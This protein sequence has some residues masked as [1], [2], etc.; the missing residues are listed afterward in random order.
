VLFNEQIAS[1]YTTE[2]PV[3]AAAASLLLLAALFQ[4]SDAI[5]VVSANALRG[6]KDTR[7][8]FILSFISYWLV[9][10]PTG[11]I[12]GLT[13]LVVPKMAA[14]GFW[15]GFIVGLSTAA[16]M[17]FYRV[18]VIQGRLIAENAL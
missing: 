18:K 12:L 1:L 16:V 6:Y 15:I 4:F 13:D 3:I 8:M 14:E 17:M 5:Q 2:L 9:G 10:F 7:A 11:I